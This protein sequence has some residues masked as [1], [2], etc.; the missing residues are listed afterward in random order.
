MRFLVLILTRGCAFS[1]AHS[2]PRVPCVLCSDASLDSL[3]WRRSC[4][5]QI[6]PRCRI[7]IYNYWAKTCVPHCAHAVTSWPQ[8]PNSQDITNHCLT[9]AAQAPPAPSTFL[10]RI[11]CCV[12]WPCPRRLEFGICLNTHPRRSFS[13]TPFQRLLCGPGLVHIVCRDGGLKPRTWIINYTS[14]AKP[15]ESKH[16]G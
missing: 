10:F 8:A 5:P 7:Y 4:G 2:G 13:L 11:P 3:A 15:S 6:L 9:V 1:C 16:L 14:A 12:A